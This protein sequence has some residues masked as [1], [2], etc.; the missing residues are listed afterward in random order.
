MPRFAANLT[1]LFTEAPLLERFT[2]ASRAG[3]EAVEFLFPY[4]EDLVAVQAALQDNG[5]ELILFNLPAGDFAAGERGIAN[6]PARVDEFHDGVGKALEIAGRLGV[7]QLNCLIGRRLDGVPEEEQWQTV[8]DNLRYAAEEAQQAGV[9]QLV[10]PLNAIDTPGFLLTTA[11]QGVEL[12][13]RVG[14]DNLKLQFDV[15]HEQRG[16][17]N[18]TATFR[19]LAGSINHVQIADSPARHQPGTGELNYPF[20][21][22]A[23]DDAG[24]TGWVSL[25]YIPEPDTESSLGWLR[26]YGYWE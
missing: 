12:I 21:L 3:F 1:M 5:L 9:T 19:E 16:A 15:Y 14:H 11:S 2:L 24:Y 26:E 13:D 10:E 6:D 17:G 7:G 22:Q 25:E 4:D 18:V 23:I 20:I 8:V